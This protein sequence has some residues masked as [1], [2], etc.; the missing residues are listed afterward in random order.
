[1][2]PA[3]FTLSLECPTTEAL[4]DAMIAHLQGQGYHVDPPG[5]KWEKPAEF[6]AR[7]GLKIGHFREKVEHPCAP[8]RLTNR[9]KSGRVLEILS[10]RAFDEFCRGKRKFKP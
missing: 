4:N 2:T 3:K 9:G 7:V 6:C 5:K 8:F 1:M 10:N